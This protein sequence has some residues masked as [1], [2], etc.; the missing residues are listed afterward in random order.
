MQC[1]RAATP[2]S[3]LIALAMMVVSLACRIQ[4][5]LDGMQLLLELHIEEALAAGAAGNPTQG[6]IARRREELAART[7]KIIAQR[8]DDSGISNAVERLA[9]DRIRVRLQR[10]DQPESCRQV[11]T[12]RASLEVHVATFPE[13]AGG[14]L[15]REELLTHYDGRL[16]GNIEILPIGLRRQSA[17]AG[18]Q[19]PLY[20]AVEKTAVLTGSD[21]RHVRSAKGEAGAW[22]LM[23]S[24]APD[25]AT[26]F[27]DFTA[28][29]RG[30]A[31]AFALDGEVRAAPII[32]G[33]IGADGVIET[34]LSRA[35]AEDVAILLR[36]G[37]LPVR[38]TILEERAPVARAP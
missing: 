29:H 8:L 31:L 12:T 30:K 26:A 32:S 3:A 19:E 16:P 20:L 25:A 10:L 13:D 35:E 11:I 24:L 38:V 33:P 22:L 36:S 1:R 2:K 28:T 27:R 17:Q 5:P 6:E 21:F 34:G 14:G 37:A 15:P 4:R 18:R 7:A 23:F 9:G